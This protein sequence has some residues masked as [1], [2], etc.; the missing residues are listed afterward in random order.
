MPRFGLRHRL[1]SYAIILGIAWFLYYESWGRHL[2]TVTAYCN[3]PICINIPKYQKD[4]LFASGK[5][6]Y[7]GGIAADPKV[8]FG[9]TV[10]LVP[11]SPKTWVLIAKIF[12]GRNRFTVEDRGGK[13]KGRHIDIYIPDSLGGH[14]IARKWGVRRMRIMINGELAD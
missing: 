5:K 6:L 9:S 3:C 14:K 10:E 2:Y 1:L 13:I 11:M 4:N 7:W 12:K 8:D